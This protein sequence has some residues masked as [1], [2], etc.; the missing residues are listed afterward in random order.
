MTMLMQTYFEEIRPALGEELGIKNRLAV[1]RVSKVVVSMGLGKAIQEKKRIE[2]A[3]KDLAQITG[4]K[5]VVCRARKSVS[6][7]KLRQGYDVGAK[8]T[9]RG[10]RMFEFLERLIHVAVP[11]T[12]D[13]RGLSPG[14]FDGHGNYSMGIADQTIFPE[15]DIDKVEFHQGMNI[16][17]VTTASND[18]QARELLTRLG[19]PFRRSDQSEV[20]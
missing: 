12:R 6:N 13:F 17:I 4:Q 2:A 7:F 20:N 14:S 15:I 11:R 16:T 5:P 10:L 19:M 1:P 9:L 8:V 18:E 3:V